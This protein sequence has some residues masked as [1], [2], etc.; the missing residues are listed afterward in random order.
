MSEHRR[1]LYRSPSGDAW[2]LCWEASN[3]RAYVLHQANEPS[4]GHTTHIE[5]GAFLA[6]NRNAPEQQALVRLI[7]TLA[8]QS[9][10]AT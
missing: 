2:F 3:G 7:G 6:P 8:Q 9:P 10:V 5:I 1:E 4:G